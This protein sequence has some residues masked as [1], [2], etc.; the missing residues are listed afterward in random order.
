MLYLTFFI[1]S[2]KTSSS[3]MWTVLCVQVKQRLFTVK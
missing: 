1:A 2:D 3:V